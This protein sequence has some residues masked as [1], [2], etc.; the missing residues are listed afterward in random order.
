[1]LHFLGGFILGTA[2]ISF[3]LPRLEIKN[4]RPLVLYFFIIL[5]LVSLL[6]LLWE[7]FEFLIDFF[8]ANRGIIPRSQLG[9]EDTLSDLLM[10]LLGGAFAHFLFIK[11]SRST[12]NS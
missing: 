1:M 10:D 4:P 12:K 8:F 7:Y 2:S 6:G 3:L 5:G 11:H 9:L